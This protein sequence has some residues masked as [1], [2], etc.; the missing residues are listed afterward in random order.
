MEVKSK[1]LTSIEYILF[2]EGS[3]LISPIKP[4]KAFDNEILAFIKRCPTDIIQLYDPLT[5]LEL[6][7]RYFVN[8]G[9]DINIFN[10]MNFDF[11]EI[12]LNTSAQIQLIF[13]DQKST[14]QKSFYKKLFKKEKAI[15]YFHFYNTGSENIKINYIKSPL[16]FLSKLINDQEI[17][18]EAL[19]LEYTKFN[20]SIAIDYKNYNLFHYFAPTRNNYFLINRILG[21]LPSDKLDPE[22]KKIKQESGK[23]LKEVKS[24][25]RQNLFNEQI[26][27]IDF[28]FRVAYKD[29]LLKSVNGL[30]PILPPLILI[31]PFHNPD[32][33]DLFEGIGIIN[34]LQVEQT[35]NYISSTTNKEDF[36]LTTA[37]IMMQQKR[38]NFL[39]DVS[40]LHSSFTFSPTI[41]FPLKGKSIYRELS[42]FRPSAFI[43][44][45][46]AKT[47]R[48][49]NK[50][51]KRFGKV[52]KTKTVSDE[53][54][55]SIKNRHGQIVA[56]SDLPIEWLV[57][58]N[59]PLSFTHDVCR[60]PETS[61]HSLMSHFTFNK[62]FSYSIPRDII[63][64]TLV[65]LG[66]DEPEFKKWHVPLKKQAIKDGFSVANC[67]G[68]ED[69]KNA[70]KKH[71][72]EFIIFDC[73]GG[74]D[75]KENST[76]LQIKDERLDGKWIVENEI[77]APLILLSA[78]GTAPTY[79]TINPIANAFFEAGA[80]AVTSTFLPIS[81]DAGSILYLRV[82]NK[83]KHAANNAIHKNWLEFICHIIRTSSINEA[84]FRVLNSSNIKKSKYYISNVK[85][86][87]DSMNFG[88]RRELYNSLNKRLS[89]I[90]LVERQ[91]FDEVIPEYLLYTNLGRGDLVLFKEWKE[92]HIKVN[93][94]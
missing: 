64:K 44:I 83:L 79:G 80:I 17:I 10:V 15:R 7:Q 6:Q 2:N 93:D 94:C 54:E 52:L 4:P 91:Y 5:Y 72:P 29:K 48:K 66:S 30:S 23:A 62:I 82:L 63:S 65:I 46:S 34:L 19:S 75:P 31:F 26:K 81:I 56:I 35:E 76:F 12:S 68:L 45:C 74:F 28:F 84:Y 40:Y 3:G 88:K 92:R 14:K 77:S 8:A 51:I 27:K 33:K 60:L 53:T 42:F 87:N 16:D 78:C 11:A 49:L 58:D 36:N 37:G 86:I 55:K 32:L 90:S 70:V 22:E 73:H 20:L 24:F 18:I 25:N 85:A 9:V 39:D 47:R 67:V 69:V 43:N 1:H 38:L 71:N 61:M 50:I 21:N 89:S 59:I 13:I 41:R 57:F